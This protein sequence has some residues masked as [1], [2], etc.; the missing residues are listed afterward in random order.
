[1]T[2]Y[3][4]MREKHQQEVNEFPLGFAFGDKQFEEMMRK[5]GLDAKKKSDL[6]KV[7]H[8]FS[9]AY[10]LNKDIPAYKE[11]SRRPG[12]ENYAQWRIGMHFYCSG[13]QKHKR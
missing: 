5:W 13:R 11:M 8:L 4:T 2:G 7:S 12:V 9:G 1:M 6:A 3:R 10:I